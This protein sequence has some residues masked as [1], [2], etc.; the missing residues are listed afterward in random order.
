MAEEFFLSLLVAGSLTSSSPEDYDDEEPDDEE[1]DDEE[2]DDEEV[3]FF[4]SSF[5]MRSLVSFFE[6][7][8]FE[9]PLLATALGF[10]FDSSIVVNLAQPVECLKV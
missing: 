6:V 8:P 7:F 3:F 1:P 5:G 4:L 9:A 10:G 2:P